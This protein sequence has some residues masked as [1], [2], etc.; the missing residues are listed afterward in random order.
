MR[1]SDT[2]T[3]S[4]A[5]AAR[6]FLVKT[7]GGK[8]MQAPQVKVTHRELRKVKRVI[9]GL[10]REVE[11]AGW[12][13]TQV[14][15]A[16]LPTYQGDDIYRRVDEPVVNAYGRSTSSGYVNQVPATAS[17][18]QSVVRR[19]DANYTAALDKVDADIAALQA[20]ISTLRSERKVIVGRAW[21]NAVLLWVDDVAPEGGE[22]RRVVAP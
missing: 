20:Q 16:A 15:I 7:E 3:I 9:P 13:P 19:L 10:G 12:D 21:T 2:A 6:P 8:I 22:H 4:G 17:G 18:V 11:H 5:N 1:Q 14:T